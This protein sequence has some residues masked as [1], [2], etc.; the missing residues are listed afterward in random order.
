MTDRRKNSEVL[1]MALQCAKRDRQTLIEAY[2]PELAG[3]P[4]V[5]DALADIRAFTRLQKRLFG[6]TTSQMDAVLAGM[7]PVDLTQVGNI[8]RIMDEYAEAEK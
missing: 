4:A 8:K 2:G 6:T 3:D 7:V 5:T 1:W